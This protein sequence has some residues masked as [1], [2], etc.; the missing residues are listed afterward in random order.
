[1]MCACMSIHYARCV[2]SCGQMQ[3]LRKE[4]LD[5]AC[6]NKEISP[7]LSVDLIFSKPHE[8]GAKEGQA[9]QQNAEKKSPD[10]FAGGT[11]DFIFHSDYL[12]LSSISMRHVV[13]PRSE[14]KYLLS[15]YVQI[16][17]QSG[18]GEKTSS[19]SVMVWA[20]QVCVFVFVRVVVREAGKLSA[21]VCL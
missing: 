8:S 21:C 2:Q 7:D 13:Q 18:K 4:D 1:M 19:D 15:Q 14:Y 6:S 9:S 3:R 11:E 16:Q 17:K 10:M 5:F 20:L 12:G